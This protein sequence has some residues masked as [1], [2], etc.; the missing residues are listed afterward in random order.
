VLI[1]LALL[2]Q[3]APLPDGNALAQRV[4]E[5]QRRMEELLNSYTYDV[6][7]HEQELDKAGRV[8]SEKTRLFEVFYVKGR[9]IARKVEENGHP[10]DPDAQKKE[11]ERVGRKVK[12]MIADPA[13]LDRAQ[14]RLSRIL[15]RYDFRAV[16]RED[17]NGRPSLVLDFLPLPGKRDLKHDN[18][19]RNVGGRVWVDE[20]EE[21]LVRV[22]LRNTGGIKFVWGLGASVSTVRMAL[23]F[24]KM[25]EVW[26]P[27]EF[28]F[29]AEGRLFLFKG[30]RTRTTET[31]FH[32][33]RFEVDS[34]EEVMPPVP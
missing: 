9:P 7:E 29:L 1:L 10:L 31:Y 13:S 21:Q 4:L 30:F 33:K 3:A 27:S 26:L 34:Q 6:L 14:L 15:A 32:Y 11:D 8:S 16:S 17:T 22:E 5:K 2:V 19:L 20:T 23:G 18:V 24:Q 12:V 28:S 25:E